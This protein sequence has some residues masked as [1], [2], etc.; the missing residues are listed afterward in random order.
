MLKG[1]NTMMKISKVQVHER[2]RPTSTFDWK[3]RNVPP[4]RRDIKEFYEE[5]RVYVQPE[6]YS[7]M[8]NLANRRSRPHNVWKPIVQQ[9]LK[10]AGYEGKIRWS[11]Y[12]GCKMCPCSPGFI[13]ETTM[14]DDVSNDPIDIWITVKS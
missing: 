4:S 11:Q 9:E 14:R 6:N 2:G 13:L 1:T 8:E 12:A 5:T 3:G 7:I 10:D